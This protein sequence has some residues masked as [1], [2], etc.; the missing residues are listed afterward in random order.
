MTHFYYMPYMSHA[1][2]V[3]G[4]AAYNRAIRAV[5]AATGAVLVAGE[6]DVPADDEHFADSVHFTDAGCR[7][8]AQRVAAAL[9]RAPAFQGLFAR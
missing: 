1:A 2:L 4:F 6:D 9:E 5:A 7:W 8:Q 3:Q